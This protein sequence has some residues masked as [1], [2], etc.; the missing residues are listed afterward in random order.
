[1]AIARGRSVINV[2]ALT[3]AASLAS[4]ASVA[5]HP[6]YTFVKS[7]IRDYMR[8]NEVFLEHRPEAVMHLAAESHVDRS[9]DGPAKFI[10]TNV[11]GTFHILEA[12][13][14]YWQSKFCPKNSVSSTLV[15]MKFLVACQLIKA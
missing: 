8:L 1:M 13:R 4:V 5:D 15:L 2:D 12:S 14:K 7:D 11:T 10:E 6:N 9:I 3:Y